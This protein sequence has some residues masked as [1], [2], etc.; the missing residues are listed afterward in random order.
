MKKIKKFTD[1]ENQLYCFTH[2]VQ[3]EPGEQFQVLDKADVAWVVVGYLKRRTRSTRTGCIFGCEPRALVV[4]K[5]LKSGAPG[6]ALL[7]WELDEMPR[8]AWEKFEALFPHMVSFA[9]HHQHL[10]SCAEDLVQEYERNP[11]DAANWYINRNPYWGDMRDQFVRNRENRRFEAGQRI[12]QVQS[13]WYA[14]EDLSGVFDSLMSHQPAPAE[15]SV[16]ARIEEA[17]ALKAKYENLRKTIFTAHKFEDMR[18]ECKDALDMKQKLDK[19]VW[20]LAP[21]LPKIMGV[22]PVLD[23]IPTC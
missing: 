15:A 19:M 5:K 13:E 21:H 22:I 12:K 7:L 16:A 6:K 11:P 18:F 10:K 2:S 23:K 8:E 17:R 4:S 3:L 14:G 20:D 9:R 1:P